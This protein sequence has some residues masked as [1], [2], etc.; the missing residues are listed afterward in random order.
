MP[1]QSAKTN[2]PTIRRDNGPYA[3]LAAKVLKLGQ[4]MVADSARLAELREAQKVSPDSPVLATE[5]GK[6]NARLSRSEERIE[7]L[8]A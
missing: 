1:K 7:D 6:I 8:A 3:K 4:Q 5:I 2:T